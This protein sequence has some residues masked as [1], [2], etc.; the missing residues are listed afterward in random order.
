MSTWPHSCVWYCLHVGTPEADHLL[1]AMRATQ[2]ALEVNLT[3]EE[4]EA[5]ELRQADATRRGRGR[6]ARLRAAWRGE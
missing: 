2:A 1:D 6:W 4:R 3:L 5:G